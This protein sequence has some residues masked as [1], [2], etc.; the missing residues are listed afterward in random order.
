M[1][2][3]GNAY[4]IIACCTFL[5]GTFCEKKFRLKVKYR[6]RGQPLILGDSFCQPNTY[7]KNHNFIMILARCITEEQ[8]SVL[9]P[10]E[11]TQ[12]VPVIN[13]ATSNNM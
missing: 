12:T 4:Y 13:Q 8:T 2:R 10:A 9:C 7:L 6:P 1:S 5:R 11:T 3:S